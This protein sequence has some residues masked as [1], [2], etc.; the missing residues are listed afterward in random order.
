[1]KQHHLVWYSLR[2]PRAVEPEQLSDAFRLLASTAG[3][4]VVIES[5]GTAGLVT[6]RLAVPYGRANNVAQQLRAAVPGLALDVLEERPD[7]SVDRAIAFRLS[8]RRR[9]LR[10][11]DA[12]TISKALLTALAHVG[13][14]ERLVLQWHLGRQLSPTVV[15]TRL[16]AR[17][18]QSWMHS[19]LTAPVSGN[20]LVDS[21]QRYALRHKQSESGWTVAGRLGVHAHSASRQRQLIAQVLGALRTSQNPGVSYYVHNA[22]A[23]RVSDASLPLFHP[24]RLNRSELASISTWPVGPT[25]DLPVVRIGSRLL[26]PS[27]TIRSKGRVIGEAT[28]PGKERPLSLLPTDALRH[29]HVIGP[30]GSGKSTLLL[31]LIRQDIEAGRSVVVIEPKGDLIED[32]MKYIPPERLND[33]VHISPTSDR[34][35]GLNPLTPSGRGPELVADQLL[36]LF[37]S[38]FDGWG[39]RTQDV[40]GAAL[41]TLAK[42]PDSTLVSLI[43]LLTDESYRR[44]IVAK[45]DDPIVL[46]GFWAAYNNMSEAERAIA[47]APAM[48]R[49]RPF[50]LRPDVRGMIGQPKP[51]FDLRDVFYQ[52][53]IVL[54]DLSKG[55]LGGETAATLGSL[56]ISKLW[57]AAMSRAAIPREKRHP[58]FVYADEYQ[59]YLH[60]QTDLADALAEARGYG[61]G[62]IL[63]HQHLG[64]LDA[65]MQQAVLSNVQSRVAFRLP[66]KD[67]VAVAAGSRLE[68]DDVESLGAYQAYAKLVADGAVQ[69]WT[70]IQTSPPRDPI[71]D[72]EV[73]KA[74]SRQNYGIDR[75]VVEAELRQLVTRQSTASDSDDIGTRKRPNGGNR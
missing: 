3:V 14:G 34:P 9:A 54:V 52:R 45:V 68:A 75:E 11:E 6:H 65:A 25:N 15:P 47:I 74:A 27:K 36:A 48:R 21:E 35:V 32:V 44:K 22:P 73:V 53:K 28:Y 29:L 58:V 63:A 2:W 42:V 26:P 70:N 37:R 60:F 10:V 4:P 62:F 59:N 57:D 24:L 50:I 67:A 38:M 71:S 23:A 13:R 18:Q 55:V 30:T 61:L 33:V 7:T 72:P 12:P 8:T 49:L 41:L 1:M 31:Q 64:Q 17:S 56:V 51:K 20:K 5:I 19:L 66:H 69:E 46:E 39:P 40:L 43:L 16:D